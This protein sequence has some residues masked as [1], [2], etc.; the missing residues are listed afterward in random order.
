MAL[1]PR[2]DRAL[3]TVGLLTC[4]AFT[5]WTDPLTDKYWMAREGEAI[6]NGQPFIHADMWGLDSG[7]AAFVPTSPLWQVYLGVFTRSL[8]ESGLH[9]AGGLAVLASMTVGI[10]LARL[11]GASR[12][13]ALLV[14]FLSTLVPGVWAPRAST[15]ATAW[16]LLLT[17]YG[18]A[19]AR[20]RGRPLHLRWVVAI[21]MVGSTAGMWIH[22][23]WT[24]LSVLAGASL[25]YVNWGRLSHAWDAWRINLACIGVGLLATLM[26]VQGVHA[27]GFAR[28]VQA[29]VSGYI[30]EWSHPWQIS[31]A[32]V[33]LAALTLSL[34]T[35]VFLHSARLHQGSAGVRLATVHALAGCA[36][37]VAGLWASRFTLQ[38]WILLTPALAAALKSNPLLGW[39]GRRQLLS[40]R[41]T[42][43]YP[44]TVLAALSGVMM[45]LLAVP[46]LLPPSVASL[47][48]STLPAACSGLLTTPEWANL[49]VF[50]DRAVDVW[51]D[52]RVDFWGPARLR[53]YSLIDAGRLP[54]PDA[55]DC[56]ITPRQPLEGL[57]KHLTASGTWQSSVRGAVVLW[58]RR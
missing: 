57:A 44:R 37:A 8:G 48:P 28:S 13:S 31:T 55:V 27:W 4:A 53:Q 58:Q 39:V 40:T 16:L 21:T 41:S 32:W 42:G 30:T 25:A 22:S 33:V 14:L 47:L 7:S 51:I 56:V 43:S 12:M 35:A 18:V 19:Q 54:V 46:G 2:F 29:N 9:I 23:S 34:A 15:I 36:F 3:L 24:A 20:Q 1:S 38:A 10:W 5:T 6:L 49:V 26:G 52:G 11:A 50:R 17:G 45:S